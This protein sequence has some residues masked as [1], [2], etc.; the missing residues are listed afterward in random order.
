MAESDYMSE[1]KS[2]LND[3]P[4]DKLRPV[5]RGIISGI[6]NCVDPASDILSDAG[7]VMC[8]YRAQAENN[9]EI[10]D[11]LDST[12]NPAPDFINESYANGMLDCAKMAVVRIIEQE[13]TKNGHELDFKTSRGLFLVVSDIAEE[14]TDHLYENLPEYVTVKK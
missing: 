2:A 7:L 6:I 12:D 9:K 10:K 4:D 3:L 11:L 5:V 1:F 8:A 13:M 14:F